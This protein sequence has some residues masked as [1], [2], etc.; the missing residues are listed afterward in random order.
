MA[1]AKVYQKGRQA[2]IL[3]LFKIKK[4]KKC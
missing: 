3:L 2:I 4:D 1:V